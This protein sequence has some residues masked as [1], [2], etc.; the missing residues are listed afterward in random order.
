MALDIPASIKTMRIADAIASSGHAE[1]LSRLGVEYFGDLSDL[2]LS[3][4]RI[5]PSIDI[6]T[7]SAWIS[8]A[9]ESLERTSKVA[10]SFEVAS[11]LDGLAATALKGI[12]DQPPAS[13]RNVLATTNVDIA[14][15]ID[16]NELLEELVTLW[17]ES[18]STFSR[19]EKIAAV[20]RFIFQQN[21]LD[22]GTAIGL[23]KPRAYAVIQNLPVVSQRDE[24]YPW[25]RIGWQHDLALI[26]DR[27]ARELAVQIA[28]ALMEVM[29]ISVKDNV[30][31]KYAK[32]ETSATIDLRVLWPQ[33]ILQNGYSAPKN[34]AINGLGVNFFVVGW[35]A[36][37][38]GPVIATYGGDHTADHIAAL[39]WA[40][41]VV[42]T[43]NGF[44]AGII[45]LRRSLSKEVLLKRIA[46]ACAAGVYY[47]MPIVL[48]L[49][50]DK[51]PSALSDNHWSGL[52]LMDLLAE[53]HLPNQA[54]D[55][56]VA[57]SPVQEVWHMYEPAFAKAISELH[58]DVFPEVDALRSMGVWSMVRNSG[59]LDSW[60]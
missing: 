7:V 38:N 56:S 24:A 43:H 55:E 29:K 22:I 49:E 51:R 17:D 26:A 57:V 34:L 15:A 1:A 37:L 21:Y 50:Q 42:H 48:I 53:L 30:W 46:I 31:I 41:R 59:R 10:S 4:L 44:A 32:S 11:T 14:N 35:N 9:I 45:L 28:K 5:R 23:S 33:A 20:C 40:D 36:T 8:H 54:E 25:S 27:L 52:W 12:N 3:E 13:L 16:S 58:L 60:Q 6:S 18:T 19:V 2:D 47:P 39:A